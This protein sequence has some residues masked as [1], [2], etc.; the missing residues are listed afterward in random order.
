MRRK[1]G[2]YSKW[3]QKKRKELVAKFGGKC[4]CDNSNCNSSNNLE[5]AHKYTTGLSGRS[6]GSW[7]RLN[8]VRMNPE[9]YILLTKECHWRYDNL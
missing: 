6:R 5:F 8:D 7:N 3:Y 9:K 4:M 1:K 2:K